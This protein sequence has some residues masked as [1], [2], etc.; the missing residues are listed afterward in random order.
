MWFILDS[1]FSFP[2]KKMDDLSVILSIIKFYLFPD[3]KVKMAPNANRTQP[4]SDIADAE[5]EVLDHQDMLNNNDSTKL[6]DYCPTTAA[7]AAGA[8]TLP[9]DY[10]KSAVEERKY[11]K[12]DMD[13]FPI[14]GG[15]PRPPMLRKRNLSL[16]HAEGLMMRMID[17][18]ENVEHAMMNM[19]HNA[20]NVSVCNNKNL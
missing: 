8:E 13:A 15:R 10:K 7:A 3:P 16:H 12:D 14:Y 9:L 11:A 17:R 6:C 1:W 5:P 20:W 18:A 19:L 4:A 2:T